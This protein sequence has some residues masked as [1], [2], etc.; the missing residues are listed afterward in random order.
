MLS[1][2]IEIIYMRIYSL[3]NLELN[4]LG[5][6]GIGLTK[7]AVIGMFDAINDTKMEKMTWQ[8]ISPMV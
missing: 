7:D 1:V 6:W 2:S 3:K 8:N 4:I 5:L